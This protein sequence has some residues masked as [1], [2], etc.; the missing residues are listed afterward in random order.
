MAESSSVDRARLAALVEKWRKD[1]RA[2]LHGIGENQNTR[3]LNECAAELEA[4][5][6]RHRGVAPLDICYCRK[7][8]CVCIA[9]TLVSATHDKGCESELTSHGYTPCRCEERAME[10]R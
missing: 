9:E 2:W 8:P 3:L 5:L 4:V 7:N 10:R 6:C 1:A